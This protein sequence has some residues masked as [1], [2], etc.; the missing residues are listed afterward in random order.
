MRATERDY[1]AVLADKITP[2]VWAEV[3]QAAIDA[4]RAGDAKARAWVAEMILPPAADRMTLSDL[5]RREALGVTAEDEVAARIE[6]THTPFLARRPG[7]DDPLE[8]AEAKRIEQAEAVAEA[9]E[10]ARRK[11]ER[12]ARK[13][14]RA[15]STTP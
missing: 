8:L 6:F 9:A 13:A 12:A 2:A 10:R 14:A 15:G 11:A 7:V 5:A 4:A 3:V 1:V